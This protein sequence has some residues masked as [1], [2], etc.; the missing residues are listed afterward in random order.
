MADDA[1]NVIDSLSLALL[2]SIYY[3]TIHTALNVVGL[4]VVDWLI[5]DV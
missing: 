2:S 1:D 4:G 5:L 3:I